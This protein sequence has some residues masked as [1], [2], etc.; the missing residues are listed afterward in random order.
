MELVSVIIPTYGCRGRLR[1]SIDS[2][3]SQTY[4]P[5]EIIVVDDNS[6]ESDARRET[7]DLM[8]KYERN[9]SVIYLKHLENRNGAA[10]RNT[11]INASHGAYVA[12]L[13]DDDSF[14]PDK[15]T[16]Q[17][18]Y[19]NSHS[20]FD[21]VYCLAS[22][23]GQKYSWTY[24]E[25]IPMKEMLMLETCM[26]TPC[27]MFRREALLSVKG[28]DEALR[29]HQDYDLL[30]RFFAAGHSI[31][32]LKEI[33]SDIG[34]NAGE[35]SPSGQKLEDLKSYFFSKFDIY[36]KAIDD[37]EPGFRKE[38]YAKHYAGVFLRHL[39]NK[40]FRRA[41]RTLAKYFPYSPK[42]FTTVIRGSIKAHLS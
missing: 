38:V 17:V 24:Y 5:I 27:L 22:K 6:P 29:R 23:N 21:A 10:A 40:D 30:I 36:I 11:G 33:L 39:K 3:L 31:G 13:D 41:I 8:K 14:L 34:T 1:D 19:L 7:E 20:E 26:Y 37:K 42:Q 15:I 35:N 18:E 2:V 32:C 16:K 28:F 9:P 25:G 4:N 12:F